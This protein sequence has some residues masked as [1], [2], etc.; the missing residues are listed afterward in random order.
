MLLHYL[1]T[2][3]TQF[4][5]HFSFSFIN[6]FGLATAMAVCLMIFL[7]V[8]EEASFDRF[9]KDA[10]DIYRISFHLNMQGELMDESVSSYAMGADILN[11][12]PEVIEMTRLSHWYE[13][14]VIWQEDGRHMSVEFGLYAESTFFDLF[15]FKLL[16]GNPKTA[17]E[18][19][20]SLVLSESLANEL[21]PQSD[22]MGEVLRLGNRQ[23][24]YRVTGII[25]DCPTNSHIR[26]KLLRSY[27]SLLETSSANFYEWDANINAMTYVRLAPGSDVE[28]LKEKTKP[29]TFEKVNYK[30]EGMGVHLTI[31]YFPITDIRLRSPFSAEMVE[32][33]TLSKVWILSAVA[34]FVLFIAGFNYVNLTIAKS[35]KRAKEVGM[36]KVLGAN[37]RS[38]SRQFYTETL[39]MTGISFI[40]GLLLT[41]FSL[42]LF[43]H[44]LGTQLSLL[45]TPWWSWIM[46]LFIFVGVFGLLA[47]LYPALFMAAFQPVKIL[48]GE[49]W[50]KP[51]RFQPRNLLLLIQFVVSMALIV[52]TLVVTLQNR[53][54]YTRN[55][56]FN[57][58]GL[59]V[60][61]TDNLDDATLLSNT[62]EAYPWVGTMATGSSFP[63]GQTYMEGVEIQG[64][65]PGIMTSRIWVDYNYKDALGLQMA[66]GQWFSGDGEFEAQNVMVNQA[67][68]RKT[69]W[70]D[71]I[72]KTIGRGGQEF[73]VAG[74]LEDFNYQSLHHEIEPLML[75]I[76]ASRP[77]YIDRSYW[78][79]V[80]YSEIVESEVIRVLGDEWNQL[81]PSKALAYHF[82]S[83]HL[84]MQYENERSF[85]RLFMGFTILA[86]IIA[87]LG[88]L[89]LS[90]FIAQQ[91]QKETGIRRVLGASVY[92]IL[93]E[94]STTFVKWVFAAAVIALPLA[95][96][97]MEK[98]LA[99]FAYAIDFPFWTLIA[100]LGGMLILAMAI[101]I[102]Q[103]YRTANI[104]P[105]ESLT[106][107]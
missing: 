19:P 7:Y 45:D 4:K 63:G 59:V 31:G 98:W 32:T 1:K 20:F 74:V 28:Q 29:L 24:P 70:D 76:L 100:A 39:L 51:G 34:L 26:Y 6:L 22:P 103:S 40:V 106:Y 107:E 84:E 94:M 73:R 14:V 95:Y 57:S 85:G 61:Q 36:R 48:K 102:I 37:K 12:F 105:V 77:N 53:H 25:E 23:E 86:I 65:E 18:D 71:P 38:L 49:F 3:I 9:H 46:V 101:V 75:N 58:Q 67:F 96:W 35:G 11:E 5:R 83:Q 44:V 80:Q 42:P 10:Q 60:I 47:G 55:L 41:E 87:M 30:F 43:N 21:F 52:C 81:F 91:K 90:S 50:T 16:R 79:V 69:N 13:P 2:S 15:A 104:N 68:V 88:V 33:G 62:F 27:T 72:G 66:D 97:Y 54:L 56:G 82:L 89:G 92:S 17:L 99:G 8:L 64:M 78:L 93:S